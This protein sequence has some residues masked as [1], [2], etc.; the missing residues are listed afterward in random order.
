MTR[1]SL[2]VGAADVG[3]RIDAWLAVK[4]EGLTRSHL[5]RL[6]RDGQVLVDG[7]P[8]KSNR[9]LRE[10]ETV[11]VD[12]PPPRPLEVEPENIP[13][14]IVYEDFDLLVVNKPQGMVTHPAQGNYSGT[15]VNALLYHVHD[16]SGINGVLRPGIVHRLDKDTSGLL[17]VA[18][19]D[20]A[21][22]RLA[23]D[24]KE[25]RVRREYQALVHGNLLADQGTVDAPIA[26]HPIQRKQMAVV[27]GGRSAVTHYQVLE[28]LGNYTLLQLQL[29]TGRTHQIRVHLA[30][31]G[32]PVVGDPAYGPRRAHFDLAGQLLHAF[33]LS[34]NHPQSGE[35]LSF[36]APLPEHFQRILRRLR[37]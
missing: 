3:Q 6:I 12:V 16:L 8:V 30:H 23:A 27:P 20:Q 11:I 1:H 13:L 25:R 10:G 18:K 14:S 9:R 19:N 17:V 32:H 29:E 5:Q 31:I 36:T 22:L 15:L 35:P 7:E 24:L 21:H 34:F 37:R 2:A 4:L 26:R 33:R 28:R